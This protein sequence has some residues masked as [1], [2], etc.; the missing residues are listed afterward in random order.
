MSGLI[1]FF[2][3]S[4]IV[5][6]VAGLWM[7]STLLDPDGFSQLASGLL[8]APGVQQA[9]ST[10]LTDTISEG[11]PELK[12]QRGQVQEAVNAV[13]SD[14][15]FVPTFQT[16]LATGYST[17]IE[18]D[19]QFALNL[20]ESMGQ[21]RQQLEQIDPSLAAQL[22]PDSRL[23][24]VGEFASN[25]IEDI[26]TVLRFVRLFI[27]L[28]LVAGLI[29]AGAGIAVA[30]RRLRAIAIFGLQIA[31]YAGLMVVG[32]VL[33]GSTVGGLT[34]LGELEESI[35]N[36]WSVVTGGLLRNM[37]ILTIVGVALAIGGWMGDRQLQR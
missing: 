20:S 27:L 29:L 18:G 24:R 36:A 15:R 4:T 16:A 32:V 31:I 14:E 11:A 37:V 1:L 5:L 21:I 8:R 25:E 19:G 23:E 28:A 26:G 22:P 12:A 17:L 34:G 3:A 10:S 7:R 33:A 2:A 9:L 6:S 30:E 13:I 35:G